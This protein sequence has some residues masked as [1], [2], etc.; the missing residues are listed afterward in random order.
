[1]FD[2]IS[3]LVSNGGYL[4][5]VF[6]MFLENVFPPIP[7]ELIMPL[8]GYKTAQ[9]ELSFGGVVLAGSVGSLL[10]Q[11]PLYF[12]GRQFGLERIRKWV[13]HHGYWAATSPRELDK[14][15][16][17]FEK[18]GRR[19]VLLCRLVPTL[20]SFISIPAGLAEMRPAVFTVY[21][22]IGT[23]IWTAILAWVGR[24]LGE[25]YSQVEQYLNPFSYL[26]LVLIGVTYLWRVFK[27]YQRAKNHK[28][29]QSE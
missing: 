2:W 23:T 7:S 3:D 18:H 27:G 16:K 17:W 6:L 28:R 5:I 29:G 15:Q 24:R 19:T 9:G 20:R 22:F 1:M 14:A 10:G 12:L 4:G 25:N 26:V 21:T 13:R 11:Y 8:A